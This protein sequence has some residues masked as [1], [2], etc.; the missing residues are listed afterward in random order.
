MRVAFITPEFVTEYGDG[1]GLGNYLDTMCGHLAA[2][3]H[4]VELFVPSQAEPQVLQHRGIRV[5]RVRWQSAP[6]MTRA[7]VRMLAAS[8]SGDGPG[9]GELVRPSRRSRG[10]HGASPRGR[11]VRDRAEL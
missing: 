7:T 10:G 9:G 4:D 11:T 8:R 5:E 3:G 1:G 6:R 2:Q